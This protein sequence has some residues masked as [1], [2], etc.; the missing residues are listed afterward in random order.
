MPR[1]QGCYQTTR[2]AMQDQDL[3]MCTW[4]EGVFTILFHFNFKLNI[5]V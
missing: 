2:V 4:L 5:K 3:N 1:K